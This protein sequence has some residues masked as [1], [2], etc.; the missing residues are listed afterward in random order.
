M[1]A[2]GD[3][4]CV[5]C[6]RRLTAVGDADKRIAPRNGVW[7]ASGGPPTVIVAGAQTS[8]DMTGLIRGG[9]CKL[10]AFPRSTT[11]A[12]DGCFRGARGPKSVRFSVRL[13]ILGVGAFAGCTGLKRLSPTFGL[14]AIYAECFRESGLTEVVL[15]SSVKF[16][17]SAAFQKC[18]SL[19]SVGF[20]GD[21][22]ES[23]GARAFAECPLRSFTAPAS[24]CRI[25]NHA[26][27]G[28]KMLKSADLSA[29]LLQHER[30]RNCARTF[31]EDGAFADS[32]LCY[33]VLPRALQVIGERAFAGCR[34]LRRVTLGEDSSL[35][36]IKAR[37]FWG[38]GLESFAAP[39]SL[40][41]IG[42]LAFGGCNRL[43]AFSLNEGVRELGRLCLWTTGVAGLELLSR[44][45][46]TPQ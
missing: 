40:R 31:L 7:L 16:I 35:E 3:G 8:R 26:F 44:A 41:K 30:W 19:R 21:A 34:G 37:T 15:P 36:E 32:G 1:Y 2:C 46:A 27:C 4:I 28:C 39:A 5:Y 10:Y 33:V 45:G 38:S 43:R 12:E 14:E 24:L 9:T 6:R 25:G 23:I 11:I 17:E 18:R 42:E 29:C 13:R 22:L 20:A